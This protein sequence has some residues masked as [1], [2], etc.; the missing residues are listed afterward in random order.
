MWDELGNTSFGA[1]DLLKTLSTHEALGYGRHN[2]WE[3]L[4]LVNEPCFEAATRSDPAYRFGLRLD[5]RGNSPAC[6]PDPFENASK[7]PGVVIGSRQARTLRWRGQDVE[8]GAGSY[9][10][11]ATGIVGLRLFPNPDFDQAAAER[12]DPEQYYTDPTYYN[13]TKSGEA[14]PGRHVVWLLSRRP[15]SD[16]AAPRSRKPQVGEPQ[17]ER[18]RAVLL[19][20]SRSSSGR[21]RRRRLSRSS[22]ST[23]RGPGPLDTSFVSTDNINNPRTMNAVYSLGARLEQATRFGREKLAGR[24]SGQQAVQRVRAYGHR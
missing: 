18:R 15:E 22:S 16:Q 24:R 21:G 5:R 23:P 10:G 8:F 20:R 17:L 4:G 6:A 3:Y 14:V 11:Y 13:D 1:V 19:G 7:Y 2:R 12:W 9:Y